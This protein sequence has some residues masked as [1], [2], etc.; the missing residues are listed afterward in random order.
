MNKT[1]ANAVDTFNSPK[2]A[3]SQQS[4]LPQIFEYFQSRLQQIDI[5]EKKLEEKVSHQRIRALNLLDELPH[6]RRSTLRIYV[7]HEY[8]P[9]AGQCQ[10][11]ANAHDNK[12]AAINNDLLGESSSG[13]EAVTNVNV[14]STTSNV[15]PNKTSSEDDDDND[16][17]KKV[18]SSNSTENNRMMHS[19]VNQWKLVLEGKLLVDH[20]DHQSAALVDQS[21]KEAALRDGRVYQTQGNQVVDVADMTS[22]ERAATRF[23]HDREGEEPLIPINFAH[24]FDEI[25]VSFQYMPG[26]LEKDHQAKSNNDMDVV[27]QKQEQQ[28]DEI[29]KTCKSLVWHRT[30]QLQPQPQPQ[31]KQQ[32]SDDANK[33]VPNEST[34]T[35][36]SSSSG[37]CSLSMDTHAF[38]AFHLEPRNE[39]CRSYE[40]PTIVATIRLH[41]KYLE[42]RYKPSKKFCETL[43]P[44][45]PPPKNKTLLQGEEKQSTQDVPQQVS[46]LF[47][48]HVHIPTVFTMDEILIAIELYIRKR[49]LYDENDPT[50]I[51]N[52]G[53]LEQLFDCKEMTMTSIRQLLLSRGHLLPAIPGTPGDSPIVLRYVMKKD[54][55]S[56]TN[57]HHPGDTQKKDN[58]QSKQSDSQKEKQPRPKRRRRTTSPA[59]S[60]DVGQKAD[61]EQ[62]SSSPHPNVLSCDVDIDVA[63]LFHSHCRDILRRI[64]MRE[65]EYTSCRTKALRTVEQTRALEDVIKERLENIVKQKGLTMG[66][67]PVLAALAKEASDGSEARIAAHL[68]SK[69]ALLLD[70]LERHCEQAH[71]CWKIVDSCR[72]AV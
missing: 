15:L 59:P 33:N 26:T 9:D 21:A 58:E 53:K 38:H 27:D 41:R 66:H 47:D 24:F 63:Q 37:S 1:T 48:N 2:H 65:Y 30:P 8:L 64:K 71:A 61:G 62:G 56:T 10:Q 16:D 36:P 52:D 17:T 19:G 23:M 12:D 31:Q 45:L 57:Q 13:T 67:Q 28:K 14:P 55:A 72:D 6:Y 50:V 60:S 3:T 70:R 54:T 20:L 68:D 29:K 69:T 11:D 7:T 43:F 18:N 39:S 46:L 49:G 35:L 32:Q 22:R 34:T 51:H 25:S 5:L 4:S 42:P 44:N 40:S